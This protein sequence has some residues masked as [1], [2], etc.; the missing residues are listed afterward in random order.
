MQIK[1]SETF[2]RYSVAVGILD[3][4]NNKAVQFMSSYISPRKPFG[5]EG[6]IIKTSIYKETD[7]DMNDP[8]KC[9][10]KAKAIGYIERSEIKS[11]QEMI[12]VWKVYMPYANNIGTELNDDN[13]NTFVGEP[14]SVCTETFI[15]AGATLNLNQNSATNLSMYLRTKFARLLL[16]LAKCSQ[17][18]TSKTYCYVPMQDFSS[19]SDIDWSKSVS[20]IDQQLYRK[21]GL[22]EEEI[23]F[24]ERM[25]KPME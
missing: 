5:L 3:K 13:Q 1:G 16:S 11:H 22:S 12:D 10:G 17:H 14:N 7:K 24:V 8:I 9:Y 20:D 2:I 4:I 19:Q 21:Y 18:G 15:V 23:A 25:I 6:N